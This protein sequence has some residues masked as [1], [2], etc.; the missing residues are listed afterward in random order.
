M[1]R[2]SILPRGFKSQ[3][4]RLSRDYRSQMNLDDTAPLCAF[5]LAKHLNILVASIENLLSPNEVDILKDSFNALWMNNVDGDKVIIHN[6][7]HSVYR[8]QSNLMHEIAHIIRKHERPENIKTLRLPLNLYYYNELHEE[9]ARY[10]GACL[11]IPR[12]GLVQAL[13]QRWTEAYISEHFSASPQMVK[14][15]LYSTGVIKQV[16]HSRL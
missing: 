2:K 4:E 10:L 1:A 16:N 12:E 6:N 11:Q 3:A 14:Y 15:R 9:E 13:R 8:Q 7:F 5:R